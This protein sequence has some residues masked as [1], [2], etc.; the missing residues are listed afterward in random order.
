MCWTWSV[1]LSSRSVAK[2]RRRR[3]C[4]RCCRPA[5]RCGIDG[6]NSSQDRRVEMADRE[7]V[8]VS[9]TRTPVGKAKRGGLATVRPDEM[10]AAVIQALLER[11]PSLDPAEIDDVVM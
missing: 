11:T 1:R 6:M 9:A 3:A 5:S 7:A 10:G 4:G 2:R 8:I